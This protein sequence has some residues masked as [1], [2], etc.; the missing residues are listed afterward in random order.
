MFN[1]GANLDGHAFGTRLLSSS[2][3]V[4]SP[5]QPINFRQT[6]TIMNPSSGARIRNMFPKK[7][8]YFLFPPSCDMTEAPLLETNCPCRFFMSLFKGEAVSPFSF[9]HACPKRENT[10]QQHR[11]RHS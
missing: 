11:H 2:F 7:E 6:E 9:E 10:L 5:C 8:E 1:F 3:V 4:L